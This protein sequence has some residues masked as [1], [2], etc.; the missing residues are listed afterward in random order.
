MRWEPFS[1]GKLM[2]YGQDPQKYRNFLC[3]KM[4]Y[5]PDNGDL[6]YQCCG[7]IY[8]VSELAQYTKCYTHIAAI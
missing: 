3:G 2:V 6:L 7:P 8:V 4:D 5:K 1:A